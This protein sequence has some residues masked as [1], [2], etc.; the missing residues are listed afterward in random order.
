MRL[1]TSPEKQ[2]EPSPCQTPSENSTLGK[3]NKITVIAFVV[4]GIG[5]PAWGETPKEK[6]Q[7]WP[8]LSDPTQLTKVIGLALPSERIPYTTKEGQ[9]LYLMPDRKTPYTGWSKKLHPNG[10]IE[11]LIHYTN[12]QQDGPWSRWYANGQRQ[13]DFMMQESKMMQGLGWKPTGEPSPTKIVDGNGP[14]VGYHLNGRIRFEG[15]RVKGELEGII[16]Y[17]YANGAKYWERNFKNGKSNGPAKEWLSMDTPSTS[18]AGT[19]SVIPKNPRNLRRHEGQF[20]NNL[21]DGDWLE[22]DDRGIPAVRRTYKAGVMVKT[23]SAY[24][25]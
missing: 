13:Y 17:W 23:A 19:L 14:C 6:K 8:D 5:L 11:D 10:K 9:R 24:A 4:F 12:G 21:K 16:S 25:D 2:G 18:R 7:P 15:T 22:F 20:V 1:N 3:V